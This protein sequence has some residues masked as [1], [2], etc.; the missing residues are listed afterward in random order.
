MKADEPGGGRLAG[1]L[2]LSLSNFVFVFSNALAK[3]TSGPAGRVPVPE[4]LFVRS[5]VAVLLLA[6]VVNWADLV[7]TLRQRPALHALRLVCSTIE[8]GCFYFSITRLQLAEA[9]TFYLCAPIF[10]TAM[11]AAF[12]GEAVDRVQWLAVAVGFGGVLIALQPGAHAIS[13]YALVALTGSLLYSISL[14]AT[15]SLRRAGGTVLVTL[16]MLALLVGSGSLMPLV[17]VAPPLVMWLPL[18]AIGVI[19]MTGYVF[20]NRALLAAPASVLAPF[21]YLSIVW[22]AVVGFAAFGDIP[23]L[24]TIVGAGVIIVAGLFIAIRERKLSAM[25][26]APEPAG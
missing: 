4:V 3:Y 15:R 21:Q 20:V 19:G 2:Y 14:V 1:I 10:L 17:W 16:Q 18:A 6:P 23:P 22:S 7:A 13:P 24:A 11:A 5:I 26:S 8:V 12:L 25:R 9:S